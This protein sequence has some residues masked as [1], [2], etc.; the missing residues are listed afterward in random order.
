M[1]DLFSVANSI[2]GKLSPTAFAEIVL[3]WN[4]PGEL[5]NLK[6]TVSAIQAV[7]LDAEEKQGHDNRV[8][9]W[10]EKLIDVMYEADDLLDDFNTTQLQALQQRQFNNRDQTTCS[11]LVRFVFHLPSNLFYSLVMAHK[12][13]AIRKKLGAISADRFVLDL[14]VRQ[15]DDDT[16]L[17]SRFRQTDSSVAEVVG[18]E[19]DK[20]NII[21]LLLSS[22][23][24]EII[25]IIS[26]VGIGGMGKT[27]LAQHVFND[28]VQVKS[29]FDLRVWVCVSDPFDV[30]MIIKNILVAITRQ[31]QEDLPLAT[32]KDMLDEEISKKRYLL[33]LDD[34]WSQ[35]SEEWDRL[36]KL[37]SSG[38]IGSRIVVTTRSTNVATIAS[39]VTPYVLEGLSPSESWSLFERVALRGKEGWSQTVRDVGEEI[40]I[41]CHRVPLAIKTVASVLRLKDPE[42]EWLPFMKNELSGIDQEKDSIIPT[43]KLSYD[44]LPSH[45]KQCFLYCRLFPKD[46]EINVPMLIHLWI[47]Q[48]F[49]SSNSSCLEQTG[50]EYFKDLLSR[51]F[52][53]EVKKDIIGNIRSCKMHDLMHDLASSLDKS[54]G[55]GAGH[56]KIYHV[57]FYSDMDSSWR[58]PD[59][60]RNN[61]NRLR[62]ILLPMDSRHTWEESRGEEIFSSFKRLRALYLH[63]VQMGNLSPSVKKLKHLRYLGFTN[64]DAISVLPDFITQLYNLQVLNISFC[65]Q[66]QQLPVDLKNLVNLRHLLFDGCPKLT[67]MPKGIGELISLQTL[68]QFMV[69]GDSSDWNHIGGLDELMGLNKLRGGIEIKNLGTKLP[70]AGSANLKEKKDLQTL[71]LSWK[72]LKDLLNGSGINRGLFDGELAVMESLQPH[73]TLKVFRVYDYA[74]LRFPP[75]ISYLTN[76][77]ELWIVDCFCCKYLPPLYHMLSLRELWIFQLVSLE[78]VDNGT[79]ENLE[80]ISG[81]DGS[82][83]PFF[84]SL[85]KLWISKCTSLKG[86]WKINSEHMS[87]TVVLPQFPRLSL[88]EIKNCPNLT[89]MPS[90]SSLREKLV[91]NSTRC[92]MVQKESLDDVSGSIGATVSSVAPLLQFPSWLPWL[93]NVAKLWI[94]NCYNCPSSIPD[95][96]QLPCLTDLYLGTMCD[97]EYLE[98]RE[99]EAGGVFFRSLKKLWIWKCPNLKGWRNEKGLDFLPPFPCLSLLDIRHCAKLTQVPSF[100]ALK[101]TFYLEHSNL[102]PLQEAMNTNHI[103]RGRGFKVSSFLENIKELWIAG[104]PELKEINNIEFLPFLKKL[105]VWDCANLRSWGYNDKAAAAADGHFPRIS[106]LKIKNCRKLSCMPLFP[107]LDGELVVENSSLE[108][109]A[110]TMKMA[111]R[112]GAP[113]SKLK[114]L[115]IIGV[116]NTKSLPRQWLE[117]LASLQEL[118]VKKCD[119]IR[120]VPQDLKL[121]P[122]LQ[123][124]HISRCGEMMNSGGD[125]SRVATNAHD[126][127][128]VIEIDW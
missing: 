64:N 56:E 106:L 105:W 78:Y 6:D 128:I 67:H 86:W 9:D 38:G 66:L 19:S 108:P 45:L 21:K 125:W 70:A 103:C 23:Q 57:S 88:L 7:L 124:L 43:L 27:T 95:L 76:L 1:A 26:I 120:L 109:L 4:L 102:F 68:T 101:E 58:V 80:G 42:T 11:T 122:C 32:L 37:L 20:E 51:F 46:Y 52:F 13:K 71:I 69:G 104:L 119:K 84:P 63:E 117:N 55:S 15:K 31:K 47:A 89:W 77:V 100:P 17:S 116:S 12:I 98:T 14:Q 25:P 110:Q 85:E 99:V 61:A 28:E 115:S 121:L 18:R 29:N 35:S 123:K 53:Q 126:E 83:L 48:G 94:V 3:L 40:V 34:V 113:L 112:G 44:H 41:K 5:R 49:V 91:L 50:L 74:G 65:S 118:Y 72:K 92:F 79:M 16:I 107:A 8:K 111:A 36:K 39:P 73:S 90:F 127:S 96:D 82:A 114:K 93:D 75:W 87:S 10:L 59:S 22:N 30:V 33:V 62:T 24:E 54:G 97:L 60:L 81:A 2:L